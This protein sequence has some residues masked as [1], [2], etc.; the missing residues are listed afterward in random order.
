MLSGDGPPDC[1]KSTPASS[2]TSSCSHLQSPSYVRLDEAAAAAET[3]EASAVGTA[4]AATTPC[5]DWQ[6][7]QLSPSFSPVVSPT[8]TAAAAAEK[9]MSYL[10][11]AD[12]IVDESSDTESL[13]RSVISFAL[14]SRPAHDNLGGHSRIGRGRSSESVES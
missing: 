9:A 2:S 11:V 8:A 5:N 7:I 3:T 13:G 14:N 12:A 10:T 4:A 1:G 6:P